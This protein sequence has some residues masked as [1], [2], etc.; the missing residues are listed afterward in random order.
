MERHELL[1]LMMELHLAGMRAV[2]DEVLRDAVRRQRSFQDLLGDLLK[3]ELAQKKAHS[4]S[5]QIGAAR[6][7]V[8]KEL[9][10]FDFAVSPVNEGLVRDL[11]D[12]DFL[13]TKR[14][15]VLVGGTGTG[16]T[17]LAISITAN[18]IAHLPLG[19]QATRRSMGGNFRL[20]NRLRL[21]SRSHGV[22]P[23]PLSIHH[24][25]RRCTAIGAVGCSPG[26][27]G[28]ER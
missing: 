9:N 2:I 23:G 14:N 28:Q 17:H 7:P 25:L 12:S 13:E 22:S 3:A 24:T 8:A 6:L 11:H 15:A 21:D 18:V 16:K 10:E 20:T 26:S 4:I 5:Y 1:A 27:V 19:V